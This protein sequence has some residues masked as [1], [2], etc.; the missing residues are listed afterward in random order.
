MAVLACL[1]G[2][3]AWAADN[4]GEQAATRPSLAIMQV[5][6]AH[7]VAAGVATL[8]SDQVTQTFRASGAFGRVVSLKETEDLLG[9]ERLRQL[10]ECEGGCVT[11]LAGALGVDY[12]ATA[13]IGKLGNSYL[14]SMRLMSVKSGSTVGSVSE[15]LR[16]NSEE[17]FLDALPA[18][19][20]AVIKQAGLETATTAPAAVPD[21]AEPTTAPPP[22]AVADATPPAAAVPADQPAGKK[23]KPA[24]SASVLPRVRYGVMHGLMAAGVVFVLVEAVIALVAVPVLLLA[25]TLPGDAMA[26]RQWRSAVGTGLLVGVVPGLL[27]L[28]VLGAT[29][30]VI[31]AVRDVGVFTQSN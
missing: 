20:A 13:K 8:L 1:V 14:M 7:G 24:A 10:A 9:L 4:G 3:P 11:E 12:L 27:L 22:A 26:T 21:A 28:A 30:T 15:R 31:S 2:T 17:A 5:E 29:G 23:D 6:A 16:E 18:A 25:P 19:V